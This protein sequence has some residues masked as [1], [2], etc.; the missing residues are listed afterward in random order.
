M[1]MT[2]IIKLLVVDARLTARVTSPAERGAYK[3]STM[4][5]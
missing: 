4:L 1:D 2:A 3:I 5:P